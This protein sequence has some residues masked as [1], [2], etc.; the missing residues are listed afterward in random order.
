MHRGTLVTT[1]TSIKASPDTYLKAISNKA[2][3]MN[4]FSVRIEPLTFKAK[5]ASYFRT[6]RVTR[7]ACDGNTI[8]P[9]RTNRSTWK[10]CTKLLKSVQKAKVRAWKDRTENT[11]FSSEYCQE[12]HR[13]LRRTEHEHDGIPG[14]NAPGP[15]LACPTGSQAS[16]ANRK[17][18]F[19]R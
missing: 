14:R 8:L 16:R 4:W 17:P 2:N 5:A 6:P 3:S 10:R 9:L 12:K 19:A 11:K 18:S 15:R 7:A 1:S 13:P